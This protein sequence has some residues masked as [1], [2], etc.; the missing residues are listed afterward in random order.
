MNVVNFFKDAFF[1]IVSKLFLV[2]LSIVIYL[3]TYSFEVFFIII[4]IL[5]ELFFIIKEC[6]Q[7]YN[8]YTCLK[9][10]LNNL[11]THHFIPEDLICPKFIDEKIALEL[12]KNLNKLAYNKILKETSKL[13]DY[14]E[15]IETW[16]HQIKIY[17]SS[18]DLVSQRIHTQDSQQILSRLDKIC[19]LVDQVLYYAKAQCLERDYIIKKYDLKE[20][21]NT[22]IKNN[23]M[24]LIENKVKI[25]VNDTTDFIYADKKWLLFVLSQILINST[26]YKRKYAQIKIY[27]KSYQNSV[28]LNIEDNGI[29]IPEEDIE[30]VFDKGFTGING[31]SYAKSTGMGLYICKKLC[32]K[33]GLKISINSKVSEFTIVKITFPK[34]DMFS[35]VNERVLP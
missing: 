14:R 13:E 3:K 17:I 25:N 4:F 22:A 19:S 31:R 7:K 9:A 30:Y 32:T 33:M 18:I 5:F 15:Y 8:Y 16:I 34:N 12:L 20:I 10:N 26:K 6:I 11:L 2:L 23:S 27:T 24:T 35:V 21:I 29:G 28:E 1:N